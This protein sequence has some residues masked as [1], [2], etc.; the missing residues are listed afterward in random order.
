MVHGDSNDNNS[1]YIDDN[2][3]D[4]IHYDRWNHFHNLS[5]ML[6]ILMQALPRKRLNK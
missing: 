2:N 6:N 1:Y 4:N 5:N 3:D